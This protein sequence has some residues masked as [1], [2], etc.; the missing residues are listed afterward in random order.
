MIAGTA[1]PFEST[2]SNVAA[3]PGEMV[4]AEPGRAAYGMERLHRARAPADLTRPALGWEIFVERLFA[5][6]SAGPSGERPDPASL[7]ELVR[8]FPREIAL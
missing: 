1:S 3:G 2:A 5:L 8:S 7:L 4:L 6:S